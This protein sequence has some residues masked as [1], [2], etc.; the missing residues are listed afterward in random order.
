VNCLPEH[1]GEDINQYS[2]SP[3]LQAR[4]S[5]VARRAV[6]A[7]DSSTRFREIHEVKAT[8][9]WELCPWLG[10]VWIDPNRRDRHSDMAPVFSFIVFERRH[11]KE[12]K[13]VQAEHPEI[14]AKLT[15]GC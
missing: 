3:R 2:S 15:A 13:N 6:R 7:F 4:H 14:V 12:K 1:A 8:G 10:M 5:A 9:N 11:W